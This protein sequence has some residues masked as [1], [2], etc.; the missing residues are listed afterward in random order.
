MTFF[1]VIHPEVLVDQ[2]LPEFSTDGCWT[3]DDRNAF[4]VSPMSQT[5]SSEHYPGMTHRGLCKY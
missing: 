1:P 2:T 4:T 3:P 5:F